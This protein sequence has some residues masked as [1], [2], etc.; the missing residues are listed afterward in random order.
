MGKGYTQDT[1]G[2]APTRARSCCCADS[3][4]IAT[5]LGTRAI[6]PNLRND[7]L[8]RMLTY[9]RHGVKQGHRFR[10]ARGGTLFNRRPHGGLYLAQDRFRGVI[11]R[12]Q[13][14]GAP[15]VGCPSSDY[16]TRAPALA[17]S[18]LQ[19]CVPGLPSWSH[20]S[21]LLST[22]APWRSHCEGSTGPL[23]EL[24]IPTTPLDLARSRRFLFMRE[25]GVVLAPL[26][27]R[28]QCQHVINRHDPQQQH[29]VQL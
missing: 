13:R 15:L 20:R 4:S 6:S 14:P 9:P 25:T 21:R 28:D 3:V 26:H 17:L 1:A 19:S 23:P 22:P 7:R 16:R 29:G 5:P 10:H 18:A 27:P 2:I 11:P 8:R 12:Q 24:I